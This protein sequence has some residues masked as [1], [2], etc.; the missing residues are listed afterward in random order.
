MILGKY[1]MAL[2]YLAQNGYCKMKV[3]DNIEKYAIDE[4]GQKY[5]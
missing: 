4:G 2:N 5:N 1:K 3:L